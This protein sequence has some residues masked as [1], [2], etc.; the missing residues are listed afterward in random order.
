MHG[1]VP[2]VG[3]LIGEFAKQGQD[4]STHGL[5]PL[6]IP[7]ASRREST[8]GA[9]AT[10]DSRDPRRMP[11]QTRTESIRM[12]ATRTRNIPQM[13]AS[14]RALKINTWVCAICAPAMVPEP[15]AASSCLACARNPTRGPGEKIFCQA[16]VK[17]TVT[18]HASG[19]PVI[20]T[21]RMRCI[22]IRI[23]VATHSAI[24]ANNWLA[25]PNSGQS[26]LIPPSGSR[27]P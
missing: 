26:E 21:Y 6:H 9:S 7:S 1:Q 27:T 4:R 11:D 24:A 25:I 16:A 18:S 17:V 2:A 10:R 3:I 15:S 22:L 23:V 13:T 8:N 12:T 14:S 19:T 20:Q 5:P